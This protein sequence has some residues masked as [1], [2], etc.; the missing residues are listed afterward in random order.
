MTTEVDQKEITETTSRQSVQTRRDKIEASFI[1]VFI[2][3]NELTVKHP[4]A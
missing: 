2:I 3:S 4:A 1:A